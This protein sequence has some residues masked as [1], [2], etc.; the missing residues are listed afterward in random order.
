MRQIDPEPSYFLAR[1]C[2]NVTLIF[3]PA[4]LRGL[5]FW[6]IYR[7]DDF[8]FKSFSRTGVNVSRK[9]L[10]FLLWTSPSANCRP[11]FAAPAFTN[12]TT[13]I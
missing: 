6:A 10:V 5:F 7:A 12:R 13:V 11:T 1:I 3:V 4:V 2:P 8:Y 9:P